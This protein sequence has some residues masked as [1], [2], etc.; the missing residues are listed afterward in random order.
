MTDRPPGAARIVAAAGS[1]QCERLLL[2]ELEALLDRL[3]ETLLSHPVLLVVP[4]R[5]LRLHL[6]TTLAAR[7]PAVAGLVSRTLYGLAA[8]LVSR[9]GAALPGDIDP[10]MLYARRLAAGEPSLRRAF[11][12]LV[13]GYR[14][15]A[16]SARDL[17]DAGFDPGHA[18]A[19][20]EV[21]EQEGTGEASGEQL[22]RARAVVRVA[23]GALDALTDAGL[24]RRSTV[25]SAAAELVRQGAL[26]A[27]RPSAVLVYG[28]ADA[29]GI[30][31]DLI[32]ALLDRHPTTVFLDR[33]PDPANPATPAGSLFGRRFR[34]RL[35]TRAE[36][37]PPPAAEPPARVTA[38][39]ALGAAAE[40][41]EVA[42]RLRARLESGARPERL[43]VVARELGGYA[44]PL[45]VQC[46]RYGVPLSG[47]AARGP[48]TPA[49]R[50]I[51]AAL[52]LLIEGRRTPVE[53]WL[54]A[55]H[56]GFGRTS[57]FDLRLA[58]HSLGAARLEEV[59]ELQ[60]KQLLEGDSVALP[61]RL[62]FATWEGG[63]DDG[64]GADDDGDSGGD[65]SGGDESDDDAARRVYARRRHVAGAT[66]RQ[67]AKAARSLCR[68]FER[69]P[70]PAP[71]ARHLELVA[72]VL[73][74]E[75]GWPADG[76][77][78]LEVAGRL[79]RG[80][81]GLERLQLSLDELRLVLR[82]LLA[83]AGRE[84]LGGEG[85]GVQVLDVTEA[86][87]RTFDH[88]FLLGLN[89]ELFPRTV[90]EDPLLPDPLR[91]L[92]ARE[93][94][95][96]LP[97]LA[98]KRE[99]AEEERYLFAQLLT[100]A[101]E[102]TVSWQQVDDDNAARTVSP[103]VER[104]RWSEAG[105]DPEPPLARPA[106]LA[107]AGEIG[108]PVARPL[109][110]S[111]LHA[112]LAGGRAGLEP[113]LELGL[114]DLP[115]P[116]A[117]AAARLRILEE[118]DPPPWQPPRLGPYLGL[119]G[120]PL[121]DSDPR[122]ADT[123]WVTTLEGVCACPWQSML[124]KLLRIEALP[125]PLE[126]LPAIDP[127][128]IGD[129]VH[130]AAE[131]VVAR[132]LG[133]SGR[134]KLPPPGRLPLPVAWPE[135]ERLEAILE[136]AAT[137]ALRERGIGLP[138]FDHVVALAARPY[139]A[140]L[141]RLDWPAGGRVQ[142]LGGEVEGELELGRRR[143]PRRLAFRA[144][145]L[146]RTAEGEQRFT[147]YKTGRVAVSTASGDAYRRRALLAQV[148]AGLRLQVPAYARAGAGHGR[149]LFL[150]PDLGGPPEARTVAVASDDGELLA[151]FD[152][153]LAAALEALD[154]G[155]FPPRVVG[156]DEDKEP[157]RCRYCVVAE[158]CVRGDSAARRRLRLWG[159]NEPS[160]DGPV[161][162][163]SAVWRLPL[164]D[165]S[166]RGKKR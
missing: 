86:R 7:R 112:A 41:R 36:P 96:V 10:L 145:R 84:P 106:H 58:L 3:G 49:G 82:E 25:L 111:L 166:P 126:T 109:A 35:A 19:L 104:L 157:T 9:S 137:E 20:D 53:R 136:R 37:E 44:S 139:L 34:E 60:L 52:A 99:G 70:D 13:D 156:A 113:V 97:D 21:L 38:F 18:E 85:G 17:A 131:A 152:R 155:A 50:C 150:H 146:D 158:A 48:V 101:P 77:A 69:W 43:A 159:E 118:M 6:L 72:K 127:L 120:P 31:T 117:I 28:F 11:E 102:L 71:F 1:R 94:F 61:V 130:R 95:G 79:E 76:A 88:L 78:A 39:R 59:P 105:L 154:E 108:P 73:E 138:G 14:P 141:R 27:P 47:L 66:L 93:G 15:A 114:A 5:S 135:D 81:R 163:A 153:A 143:P 129:V 116:R 103:L 162:A 2:A 161:A 128:L 110:E 8:E 67:A 89:G 32:E 122:R 75:L 98:A 45:R 133:D 57:V 83:D 165:E 56:R 54:D 80:A 148:R 124:T 123:V 125:D 68:R 91:R 55:R 164:A 100:A 107:T 40:T 24:G 149:Y 16:A 87:G 30:A 64:E 12:H 92:L 90:R 23:A 42:R 119:V 46:E 160:G 22:E 65:D 142:V 147:D 33:P 62:G 29:T 121:D 132:R 140:E 51:G 26:E 115:E 4:S 144:D 74:A 151:E 63:G 134:S